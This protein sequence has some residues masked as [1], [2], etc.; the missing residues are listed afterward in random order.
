MQK[1]IEQRRE[2]NIETWRIQGGLE[3]FKMLRSEIPCTTMLW[4]T[5]S[6]PPMIA[7]VTQASTV[8]KARGFKVMSS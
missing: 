8:T 7:V 5:P 4:A 6:R 2:E 3:S 1:R